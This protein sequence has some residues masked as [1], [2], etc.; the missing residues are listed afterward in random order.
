VASG[1]QTG[2]KLSCM[3]IGLVH[4]HVHRLA[5]L[6]IDREVLSGLV[7]RD[8]DALA[9]EVIKICKS[10]AQ[11][12]PGFGLNARAPG[13]YMYGPEAAWLDFRRRGGLLGA[14]GVQ[15]VASCTR[16]ASVRT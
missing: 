16:V 12:Q 13:H 1:S 4:V 3:F 9:L 2:S 10:C 7:P 8:C 11:A 14:L 5:S 6:F 15:N